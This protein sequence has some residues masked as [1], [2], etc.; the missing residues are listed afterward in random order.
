M[1]SG[2]LG[3]LLCSLSIMCPAG[4]EIRVMLK[5]CENRQKDE[6]KKYKMKGMKIKIGGEY[7]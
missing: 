5:E 6:S 4:M 7:K 1:L 2:L 3:V